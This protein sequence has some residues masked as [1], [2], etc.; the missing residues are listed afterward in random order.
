M[1]CEKILGHI[2]DPKFAGKKIDYVEIEW[3]EA[4][5]K[6]HKKETRD[7]EAIGIRMDHHILTRGLKDGDVLYADEEKVVVV[8]IPACEVIIIQVDE[9]HPKMREKV[10]YEIGNK[11]ATLFWGEEEGTFITPYNEPSLVMLQKIHGV[12]AWRDVIKLNF[13]NSISSSI[14]N[15]H[16]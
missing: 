6:L 4:F 10:C 5:K 13:E 3:H 12:T 1:L 15:H 14:N 2:S 8:E 11:H 7:G 16:H 9:H